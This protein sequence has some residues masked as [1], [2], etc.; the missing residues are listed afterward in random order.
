MRRRIA[1]LVCALFLFPLAC[2]GFDDEWDNAWDVDH[3]AWD[4]FMPDG[5]ASTGLSDFAAAWAYQNVTLTPRAPSVIDLVFQQQEIDMFNKLNAMF[6]NLFGVQNATADGQW[7]F[8]SVVTLMPLRCADVARVVSMFDGALKQENPAADI[9]SVAQKL[10]AEPCNGG[11]CPCVE[12]RR[13][14]VR[15]LEIRS[16]SKQRAI[17]YPANFPYPVRQSST[18]LALF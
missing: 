5:N 3:S 8:V 15:A 14:S 17:S 9:S 12:T 18:S 16:T 2:T 13:H 7:T 10:G 1:T 6:S 11:I 4:A